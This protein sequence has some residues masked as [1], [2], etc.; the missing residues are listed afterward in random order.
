MPKPT[1]FKIGTPLDGAV[2]KR[3]DAPPTVARNSKESMHS[4]ARILTGAQTVM[5]FPTLEVDIRAMLKELYNMVNEQQKIP[6]SMYSETLHW[7]EQGRRTGEILARCTY[8]YAWIPWLSGLNAYILPRPGN[9]ATFN[10]PLAIIRES[11]Y[12]REF[13]SETRGG[14]EAG[15]GGIKFRKIIS[16]ARGQTFRINDQTIPYVRTDQ[17][18]AAVRANE[19]MVNG[20]KECMKSGRTAIIYAHLIPGHTV[21][22]IIERDPGPDGTHVITYMDCNGLSAQNDIPSYMEA[23]VECIMDT[24]EEEAFLEIDLTDPMK[25]VEFSK[26]Y[27]EHVKVYQ[28][29]RD[30]WSPPIATKALPMGLHY[31]EKKVGYATYRY[32]S[33]NVHMSRV[34]IGLCQWAAV[35]TVSLYMLGKVLHPRVVPPCPFNDSWK[36]IGKHDQAGEHTLNPL[37]WYKYVPS[38]IVT[39]AAVDIIPAVTWLTYLH[40]LVEQD[41]ESATSLWKS[42]EIIKFRQF[43]TAIVVSNDTV[44]SSAK[45][46]TFAGTTDASSP[47]RDVTV[48]LL[49][50][51]GFSPVGQNDKT[52]SEVSEVSEADAEAAAGGG[53]GAAAGVGARQTLT[54]PHAN[55]SILALKVP[56][57]LRF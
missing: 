36:L 33:N 42:P 11:E 21:V 52:A 44:R 46:G 8:F 47:T 14:A 43:I 45:R 34:R 3:P 39:T 9:M 18:V 57:V 37:T 38:G 35:F 24:S 50:S 29:S 28:S 2:V 15:T 23:I 41:L 20:I 49:E 7:N 55:R 54:F 53:G 17:L 26:N 1:I 16:H 5:S 25:V 19:A 4:W 30:G 13:A 22:I 32:T 10:M 51:F 27:T 31:G 12:E 40:T 6:L 56:Q 48:T